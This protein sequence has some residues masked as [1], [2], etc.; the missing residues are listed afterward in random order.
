MDLIFSFSHGVLEILG[1]VT[2]TLPRDLGSRT[3]KILLDTGDPGSSL[4]MLS[5]D[6][7]DLGS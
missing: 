4:G 2:A 7:A 3:E 5:W 6:P 1:P